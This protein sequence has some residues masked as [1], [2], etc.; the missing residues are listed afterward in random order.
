MDRSALYPW[1]HRQHSPGLRAQENSVIRVHV[2]EVLELQCS[3]YGA[4]H[5]HQV[6]RETGLKV[7]IHG[8]ARLCAAQ[9]LRPRPDG[10]SVLAGTQVIG[11]VVWLRTCSS[12]SSGQQLPI[13]AGPVRSP[14]SASQQVGGIWRA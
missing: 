2:Q 7:G 6:L 9:T 12:R 11:P 3:F 10:D 1:R 14:T 13:A 8:I 5:V 4:P